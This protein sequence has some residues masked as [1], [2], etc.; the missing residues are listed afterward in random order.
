MADENAPL[1]PLTRKRVPELRPKPLLPPSLGQFERVL[2]GG[3]SLPCHPSEKIWNLPLAGLREMLNQV[4]HDNLGMFSMT[5]VRG[6]LCWSWFG[7]GWLAL[8]GGE[9]Y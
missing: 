2:E 8:Q 6:W 5:I 9:R 3:L 7:L 4:Q 1:P